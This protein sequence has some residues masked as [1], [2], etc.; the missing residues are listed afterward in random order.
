MT[1]S[2]TK[3]PQPAAPDREFDRR[4]RHRRQNADATSDSS[5]SAQDD[6]AEPPAVPVGDPALSIGS[7]VGVLLISTSGDRLLIGG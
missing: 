7:S 2:S 1:K 6:I 3:L 4:H 5:A